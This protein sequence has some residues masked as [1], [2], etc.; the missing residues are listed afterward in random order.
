MKYKETLE[1]ALSRDLIDERKLLVFSNIKK[2]YTNTTTAKISL[3]GLCLMCIRDDSF[4][5]YDSDFSQKIGDLLFQCRFS[6]MKDFKCSSFVFNRYMK[7]TYN[8]QMYKFADFGM[9]K[10]WNAACLEA[11]IKK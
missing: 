7:F 10:I 9:A 3:Y 6:E 5:V 11:I 4:F 2:G 8:N 1:L